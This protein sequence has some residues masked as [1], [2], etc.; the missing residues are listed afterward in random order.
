MEQLVF[1]GRYRAVRLLGEGG[2]SKVYLAQAPDTTQPVVVKVLRENLSANPRFRDCFQREMMLLQRFQH[3]HAVA[4]LEASAN[5]PRGPCI[6]MEYIPG[7]DLETLLERRR[8]LSPLR[9]GRLLT[10]ICRVLQ[11]AHNQGIVHRDL[12]PGNLMVVHPDLPTEQVKVMD[13]GL[14]QLA[15]ALYIPLEKL[16]RTEQDYASGTPEYISPEEVRRDKV[17]HRCDFY[18]LGVM[19]YQLLTGRLPFTGSLEQL[20]DAHTGQAPPPF[21]KT[22]VR[23]PQAIEAVVMACLAKYP[24][25]RPQNARELAERYE[26][27][28]GQRLIKEPFDEPADPRT[29]PTQASG[30][31]VEKVIDPDTVVKHLQAFMPEMVAVMKLRGF[32]NDIGGEAVESVPG[33]IRVRLGE[34]QETAI[35]DNQKLLSWFGL[36]KKSATLT[37]AHPTE[38]ELHMEKKGS[39]PQGLL[40]LTVLLRPEGGRQQARDPQWHAFCDRIF[41]DLRAYLMGSV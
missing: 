18:S 32:V 30:P 8:R 1:L 25:E 15:T 12:K 11:S 28:L 13:F 35:P 9:V 38:M 23:L 21:Q 3:P 10:Q 5:D 29:L 37:I 39:S 4:L 27:A 31:L 7:I 14:A 33:M 6:V 22:G 17:D 16:T 36:G 34:R 2:T 41:R 26:L 40:Q 20:L 19:L 24:V